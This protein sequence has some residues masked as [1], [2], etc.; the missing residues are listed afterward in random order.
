MRRNKL[1][2]LLVA[3]GLVLA[4]TACSRILTLARAT[5]T[6]QPVQ[7]TPTPIPLTATA[8]TPLPPTRTLVPAT[9]TPMQ[10]MPTATLTPPTLTPAPPTPTPVIYVVQAG[11]TLGAIAKKFGVTVAALQEVNAI[12]DPNRLQIDQELVIPQRQVEA[13]VTSTSISPIIAPDVYVVQA[14]DTL[15]AIAKQYGVTVEALQEAN[16]ISDPTRL[17]IGQKLIIPKCGT[18]APRGTAT[19]VR[20]T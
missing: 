16:A 1:G 3:M 10:A 12:S 15:G 19:E 11:D 13:T 7:A 2:F 8:T 5:P 6:S 20:A 18:I 9:T 4:A 17:Q 14:G